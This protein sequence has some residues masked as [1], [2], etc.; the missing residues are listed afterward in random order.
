MIIKKI[1]SDKLVK[2]HAEADNSVKTGGEG[3]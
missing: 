1:S 3:A 2:Y